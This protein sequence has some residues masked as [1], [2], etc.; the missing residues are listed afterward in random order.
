MSAETMIGFVE[1][2][3]SDAGIREEFETALGSTEDTDA[4]VIEFASQHG[5]EVTE[6]DCRALAAPAEGEL[7]LEDL[8]LEKVAGGVLSSP[9]GRP[10]YS[11]TGRWVHSKKA[12]RE[13]LAKKRRVVPYTIPK[14]LR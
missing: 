11:P 2:L 3:E 9:T 12:Y 4:T 13:W 8:E 6:E 5:F 10:E 14:S 1:K 7:D